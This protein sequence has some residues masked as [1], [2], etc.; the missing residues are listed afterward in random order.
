MESRPDHEWFV[1][2]FA[3]PLLHLGSL[4][5]NRESYGRTTAIRVHEIFANGRPV[6]GETR[7]NWKQSFRSFFQGS[8]SIG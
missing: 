5:R 8:Q 7:Q 2:K 1:Q 3:L 4:Q 6:P